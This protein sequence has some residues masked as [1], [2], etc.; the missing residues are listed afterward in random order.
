ME[1]PAQTDAPIHEL[2]ARRWSPRA[3]DERPIEPEK[4]ASLFE[5][6]RWAPSSNNEQPWRFLVATREQG[7]EYDRLLDC[8]LEGNRKWAYRAPVLI[9][10]VASMHFVDGAKA[11]RHAYHDTGMAAENLVLQATASGLF[12]HQMAGF[13]VEKARADFNIPQGFEP[14]AMIAVGYAGDSQVLPDYLKQRELAPR[15]RNPVSTFV[16]SGDWGKP[17]PLVR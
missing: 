13:N 15:Q 3:F 5:A 9:L 12:A 8:L 6:A 4:L 1:K 10:S 14:V 2:L 7:G 17:S 11:N 16:F